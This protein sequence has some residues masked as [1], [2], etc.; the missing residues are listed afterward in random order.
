MR[1]VAGA[2]F[3]L[4]CASSTLEAQ[5]TTALD[6]L[7]ATARGAY[8]DGRAALSAR[9]SPVI[10]V[11]FDELV[12]LRD[13]KETREGFTPAAYHYLK[14]VSHV[15]LGVVALLSTRTFG[16][17]DGP[18]RARLED[19]RDKARA[20]RSPIDELALSPAQKTRLQRILA[21]SLA[22]ID[23]ALTAGVPDAASLS[24]YAHAMAPLVLANA[25]DAAKLQLDAL[26]ALVQRWRQDLSADEWR[27][28]YVVVLGGKL[29]RVGNLQYAYFVEALGPG[30]ADRRV[31]YAEG[32]FDPP[33]GLALL[34]TI[35]TDR[36]AGV[37]FFGD[38]T[39][40]ERDLLSDA[41]KAYL[42]RLFG[43]LGAD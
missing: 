8:A 30:S 43:R 23:R 9:T 11:A 7:N 25:D 22:M 17:R 38:E 6:Q 13:G 4:L 1:R 16:E 14:S 39:R 20:A 27:R 36:S 26:H 35:V 18:W 33:G 37:A 40:L 2:A 5:D 32:I 28:V 24:G 15:P 31:I 29:P 10:V 41:A 12:L 3:L 21:G 34:A 42:L 19:L